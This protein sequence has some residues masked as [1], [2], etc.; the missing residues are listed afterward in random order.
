V[1]RNS[2]SGEWLGKQIFNLD[3]QQ[4]FT[5]DDAIKCHIGWFYRASN[6][7]GFELRAKEF[8]VDAHSV[9]NV[10]RAKLKV[11]Y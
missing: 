11:V 3:L 4:Q 2:W 6:C 1:A 9:G 7:T 10:H 5:F 8:Q